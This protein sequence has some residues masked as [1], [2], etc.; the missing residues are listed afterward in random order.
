VVSDDKLR[1]TGFETT[2]TL[3]KGITELLKGYRMLDNSRYSNV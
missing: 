1:A 3:D 2:M